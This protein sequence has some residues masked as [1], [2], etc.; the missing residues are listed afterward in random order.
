MGQV[1]VRNLNDEVVAA[2][3]RK[4]RLHG[5]PLEQ[6]LREILTEAARLSPREKAALADKIASMTQGEL[7]TDSADLI[8]ADRDSR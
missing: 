3:K 5:R 1:I 7:K 2:L 4:A 6:E 8:R